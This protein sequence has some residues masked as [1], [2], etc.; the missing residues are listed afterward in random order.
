LAASS[1]ESFLEEVAG[2][3]I[4]D[5]NARAG[6]SGVHGEL[7]LEAPELIQEMDRFGIERALVSHFAAEEYD[8]H[9]GNCNLSR[10][11][12]ARL[13]PVWAALPDRASLDELAR[14]KPSAVRLFF[15]ASRH[16]F[17][18]GLWCSGEL[19]D[20][21]QAHCILTLV[22]LEDIGWSALATTLSNFRRLP[23]LLLETGY[24]ADRY[25]FPLLKNFPNL[26]FDTAT[27]L[28]HRQLETFVERFGPGQAV[29]GSRLPFYTP[30]TALAV[31]ATARI[32]EEARRAI[33][34]ENLKRLVEGAC[35]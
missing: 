8:A 33:A 3:H 23:I 2:W 13:V 4:F 35:P 7:A 14:R 15:G 34:G 20:Y 18:P 5:A 27:Y 11:A 12:S 32:S 10:V 30:A 31:L 24:R 9:E 26:S 22:A 16:N 1:I 17:S 6:K 21:L 19:L 28:A 29:F 25:L